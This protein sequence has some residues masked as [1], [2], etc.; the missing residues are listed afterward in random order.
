MKIVECS[1]I[2]L[3]YFLAASHL[4]T[5]RELCN[6]CDA[7]WYPSLLPERKAIFIVAACIFVPQGSLQKDRSRMP[8]HKEEVC[9]SFAQLLLS[10]E[11]LPHSNCITTGE[12]SLA[13]HQLFD[14]LVEHFTADI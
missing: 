13:L 9:G 11:Q 6:C 5:R 12:S 14:N 3:K 2:V 1:F 7:L 4:R 10:F 8:D